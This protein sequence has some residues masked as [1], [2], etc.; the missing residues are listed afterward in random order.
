MPARSA[1]ER[2]PGP[3]AGAPAPP[4][5]PSSIQGVGRKRGWDLEE[6]PCLAQTSGRPQSWFRGDPGSAPTSW[7]AG[8]RRPAPALFG[9]CPS[10][11]A[12]PGGCRQRPG[13]CCWRTAD[14]PRIGA[15]PAAEPGKAEAWATGPAAWGSQ[16]EAR[17]TGTD[18]GRG[19]EGWEP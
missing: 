13:R 18:L 14:K 12:S 9:S 19:M 16:A 7:H 6:A 10:L 2:F 4:R 1:A 15:W 17:R 3:P 11:K 5:L 8:G